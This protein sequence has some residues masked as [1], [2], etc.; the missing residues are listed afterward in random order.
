[1]SLVWADDRI[2]PCIQNFVMV[3]AAESMEKFSP[4]GGLTS[5]GLLR[6][7]G[8]C[9]V[10]WRRS[11]RLNNTSEDKF[12]AFSSRALTDISNAGPLGGAYTACT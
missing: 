12:C 11:W 1:V 10:T 9:E 8:D 2:Y 5:T 6:D 4:E 7:F 3:V